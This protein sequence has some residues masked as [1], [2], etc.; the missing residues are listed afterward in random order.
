MNI[1]RLTLEEWGDALPSKP[2]DG[3][4]SPHSSSVRR[5]MFIGFVSR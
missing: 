3:R 2:F 1:E 5:S 4:A